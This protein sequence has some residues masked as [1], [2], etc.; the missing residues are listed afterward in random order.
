MTKIST[1]GEFGLIAEIKSRFSG[2]NLPQGWQ[3]I[4][5]DCAVIPKDENSSWLI[6]TDMFLAGVHFLSDNIPP[7]AAGHKSLA[8]NISDVAAM[9]GKACAVLLSIALP[10]DT[11]LEWAQDFIKGFS[12]LAER[13]NIRL[14]GGDT[15][16]SRH[17]VI[18]S[19]TV[20]GESAN[21]NIKYRSAARAGDIIA[22][23]RPLGGSAAGLRAIMYKENNKDAIQAHYWPDAEMKL[24]AFLGAQ[25]SVHA[26]MDISDGLVQDLRHILDASGVG[27]RLDIPDNLVHPTATLDQA[28]SGGEDYA[29]LFTVAAHE[30][31]PLEKSVQD[32]M[33]R[34]IIPIGK[35]TANPGECEIFSQGKKIEIHK[36]GFDHFA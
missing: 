12:E 36:E 16:K 29:L 30:F 25:N 5:D 33:G 28:L 19:I 3:G 17:D 26:M 22:V 9:G 4:G 14:I 15:S 31:D 32:T 18:V 35:I 21:A 20:I 24:G 1:L 27:A 23:S 6:S 2:T 34:G 13:E 10:K 11:T 7:R 8:V